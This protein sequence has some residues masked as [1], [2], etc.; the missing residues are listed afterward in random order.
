MVTPWYC[1]QRRVNLALTEGS[2]WKM[3]TR[4]PLSPVASR[5]PS[6]LNSTHEMMSAARVTTDTE[7]PQNYRNGTIELCANQCR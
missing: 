3:T 1:S 2:R 7:F 6:W 4:P 5:S